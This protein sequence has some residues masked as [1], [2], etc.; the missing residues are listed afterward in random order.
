VKKYSVLLFFLAQFALSSL[1]LAQLKIIVAFPTGG[2]TDRI[3][4]VLAEKLGDELKQTVV[5]ENKPGAS[6]SI[7]ANYVIRSATPNSLLFLSSAGALTI[8]PAIDPKLGYDP[9]KD[10]KPV[11]LVT[12]TTS[13][14]VV[15]APTD[16]VDAA[17]LVV[18]IKKDSARIYSAG[19]S[20]IGA[21][22]HLSMEMFQEGADVKI[23]HVPY[24]GAAAVFTDLVGKRVDMF[25]GDLPGVQSLIQAEKLKV[26]GIIGNQRSTLL[27][28]VRTLAEQGITGVIPTAW[29]GMVMAASADDAVIQTMSDALGKSLKDPKVISHLESMGAMPMYESTADFKDFLKKDA[30]RWDALIKRRNLKLDN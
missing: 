29:Y 10:F 1:A 12:D 30:G 2:P 21:T 24:K 16:I 17:D 19:S 6:G 3:A 7:A 28:G 27:P 18:R 15:G 14:L 4:R 13:V 9:F 11:S 26:L 5:V 23:L 25:F 8:N 22:S 20:G